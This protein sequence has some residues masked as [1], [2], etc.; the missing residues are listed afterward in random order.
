MFRSSRRP[1]TSP[2]AVDPVLLPSRSAKNSRIRIVTRKIHIIHWQLLICPLRQTDERWN[3]TFLPGNNNNNNSNSRPNNQISTAPY[4]SYSK[5]A[6]NLLDSR[7]TETFSIV[8]FL[9]YFNFQFQLRKHHWHLVPI[10]L[11]IT[12][13][14]Q[15]K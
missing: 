14:M 9:T 1:Q 10:Y 2:K 7:P 6:G 4:A 5:R 12:H 3:M 13:K 15:H 8:F 11:L